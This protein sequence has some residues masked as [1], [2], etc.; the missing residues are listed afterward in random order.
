M[1]Y[2]RIF[3]SALLVAGSLSLAQAAHLPGNLAVSSEAET[4]LHDLRSTALAAEYDADELR[5]ATT[6]SNLGPEMHL[7]EL[8]A[9]KSE[10]NTMGKELNTLEQERTSLTPWEQQVIAKAHPLLKDAAANTEN[11]INYFNENR[12]HLWAPEYRQ[13]ADHAWQDSEQIQKM[14]KNYL[15]YGKARDQEQ[16]YEGT[17]GGTGN[18]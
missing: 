4:T 3:T 10:I 8:N 14:L 7:Y 9:L 5:L 15:S 11:A 2:K 13:Y 12:H 6:N 16:K 18:N 1:T 17:I